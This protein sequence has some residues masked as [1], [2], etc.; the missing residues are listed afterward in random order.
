MQRVAVCVLCAIVGALES[1]EAQEVVLTIPSTSDCY[2]TPSSIHVL[3]DLTGDGVNEIALSSSGAAVGA[4]TEAGIVTVCNG[5]DGSLL[6]RYEGDAE[7][8]ELGTAVAS[9][10]DIDQDGVPDFAISD[11]RDTILNDKAGRVSLYSGADGSLIYFRGALADF[12]YFGSAVAGVGDL[13]GNGVPDWATFG[14]YGA[15]NEGLVYVYEGS[16]GIVFLTLRAEGLD[17]S[18]G[19][20]RLINLQDV[21]GDGV[22]DLAVSVSGAFVEPDMDNAGRV[23]VI[24]GADGTTLHSVNGIIAEGCLGQFLKYLG[25][26]SGDGIA[27]FGATCDDMRQ[28]LIVSGATGEILTTFSSENYNDDWYAYDF[29]R[30]GDLNGD[31]IQDLVLTSSGYMNDN[32]ETVGRLYFYLGGDFSLFG[33]IEGTVDEPLGT[34]IHYAGQSSDGATLLALKIDAQASLLK[35]IQD[36]GDGGDSGGPGGEL[37]PNDYSVST[38]VSRRG[39]VVVEIDYA[40]NWTGCQFTIVAAGGRR[41]RDDGR[42]RQLFVLSGRGAQ[43]QS[44]LRARKVPG[45]AKKPPFRTLFGRVTAVC[46]SVHSVSADFEVDFSRNRRAATSKGKVLRALSRELRDISP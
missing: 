16:T 33:T 29:T 26:V 27:D 9:V 44:V 15:Q 46:N 5:A 22:N 18:F 25:D 21:N 24:S 28:A 11:Q 2:I 45:I 17:R 39:T 43:D 34:F 8:V 42:G 38:R 37:F 1:I 13:N 30:A 4:F 32:N 3:E 7:S 20:R 19:R 35:L 36:Q 23:D 41:G 6:Y 10:G 12:A 31:G 14:G 40:D